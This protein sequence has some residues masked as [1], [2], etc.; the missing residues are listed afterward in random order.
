MEIRARTAEMICASR[1]VHVPDS[2]LTLL[3][4]T[5][6]VLTGNQTLTRGSK[7]EKKA[8]EKASGLVKGLLQTVEQVNVELLVFMDI[9]PDTLQN[10]HLHES[11]NNLWLC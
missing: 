6:N 7:G 5:T 4:V 2:E 3:E 11:L 9:L 1:N 8:L 10:N